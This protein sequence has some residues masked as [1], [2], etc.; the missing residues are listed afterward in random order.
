[1]IDEYLSDNCKSLR[2]NPFTSLKRS[3]DDEWDDNN[4]S[5]SPAKLNF[6]FDIFMVFIRC[7]IIVFKMSYNNL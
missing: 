2:L 3:L 7:G 6:R 4:I 5:S 1:M